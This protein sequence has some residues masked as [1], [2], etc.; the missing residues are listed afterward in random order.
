M[1]WFVELRRF[2]KLKKIKQ[3]NGMVW[4]VEPNGGKSVWYERKVRGWKI[5]DRFLDGSLKVRLF[6]KDENMREEKIGQ[7]KIKVGHTIILSS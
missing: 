4:M 3:Q 1:K 7:I 2:E 5:Y 6:G